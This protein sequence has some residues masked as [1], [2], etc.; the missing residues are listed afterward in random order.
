MAS[1]SQSTSIDELR[2]APD[3]VGERRKRAAG[4]ELDRGADGVADGQAQQ[5]ASGAVKGVD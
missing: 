4:R 2:P 5:G 1:K 3:H